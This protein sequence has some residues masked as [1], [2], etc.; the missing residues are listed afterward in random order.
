MKR[1]KGIVALLITVLVMS[2]LSV[3]AFA[4]GGKLYAPTSGERYSWSSTE[5]TWVKNGTFTADYKKDGRITSYTFT[6]DK[7][8]LYLAEKYT[9]KGALLSRIDR[10]DYEYDEDGKLTETTNI[11]TK[12][13][14]AGS[15]PSKVTSTTTTEAQ[16]KVEVTKRVRN[17]TWGEQ[18]GYSRSTDEET[19]EKTTESYDLTK[20]GQ[21]K[22]TWSEHN[23]ID[24]YSN[25]NVKQQ[26]SKQTSKTENY[27][28]IRKFNKYG[29]ETYHYTTSSS[30]DDDGEK[31]THVGNY[32]FDYIWGEGHCPK[33]I[34]KTYT[35]TAN[36]AESTTFKDRIVITGT[37]KV[38]KIWK[39]DR[40]GHVVM[41]FLT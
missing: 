24:Y 32:Q 18:S 34:M 35:S 15:L 41:Q 38:S 20:K 36:G 26:T 22:G 33:E 13:K 6:S 16:G 8:K 21:L 2:M 40:F 19:D 29:Y 31:Y 9:W 37:K 12:Y 17:Y 4:K 30:V 11:V 25:G 1:T 23:K 27:Y 5:N 39:C 14:Y 10:T 7:G 28:S 3:T